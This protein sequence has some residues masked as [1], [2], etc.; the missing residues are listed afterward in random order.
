MNLTKSD[1]RTVTGSNLR[2]IMLKS[3]N[4]DMEELLN[5]KVEFEYHKMNDEEMWK[6]GFVKE[7][8]DAL[9]DEKNVGLEIFR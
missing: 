6:V 3:G 1:V 4:S 8:I 2:Y 7:I 9:H 5:S